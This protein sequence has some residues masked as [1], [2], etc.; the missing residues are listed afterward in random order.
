M[1]GH[2]INTPGVVEALQALGKAGTHRKAAPVVFLVD[3]PVRGQSTTSAFF[4]MAVRWHDS[5]T[6]QEGEL[7]KNAEDEQSSPPEFGSATFRRG[8]QAL[9]RG[10]VS[11][12]PRPCSNAHAM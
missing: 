8:R 10:R 12:G 3:L 5:V 1:S 4:A 11:A 6:L 9:K 2:A 7:Q